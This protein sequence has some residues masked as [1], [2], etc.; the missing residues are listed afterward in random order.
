MGTP[1][2]SL[3][4]TISTEFRWQ[5][6][7]N[8]SPSSLYNP[9]QNTGDIRKSQAIG[10]AAGGN[11]LSG[12]GDLVFSFQQTITLGN[13]FTLDLTSMTDV[14]KR[15]TNSLARLKALQIRV[16][17]ATDDTI[18]SPAPT[19]TS[20]V[21]VTNIGPT[22]PPAGGFLPHPFDFGNGGSGGTVTL[23][24]AG[25]VT[26]V[27]VGVGGTGYPPS[28]FF[29]ASPQQASGSGCVFL[30]GTNPS[31]VITSMTFIANAGGGGYSSATVALV[32][33]GQYNILTGGTHVY[34]DPSLTGTT[35]SATSKNVMFYNMDTAKS[36]TLEIDLLGGSS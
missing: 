1:F 11:L 15:A 24:A 5:A 2:D 22:T 23:T 31:G 27:A 16:L 26:N 30:C 33:V 28:T 25:A 10:T 8:L 29:L 6:A 19:A 14:V 9:V 7:L 13:S 32:P 12:G 3:A 21:T 17:S 34:F 20:T 35:V 4:A 36:V 18:I